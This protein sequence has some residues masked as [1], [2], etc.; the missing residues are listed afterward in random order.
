MS[1][2]QAVAHDP[3]R[4]LTR[5][6]EKMQSAAPFGP[7]DWG[8]AVWDL[9]GRLTRAGK[10]LH[11]ATRD[12]LLFIEHRSSGADA[13]VPFAASF[14]DFAKAVICARHLRSSQTVG[15][16]RVSVRALRY[17]Y[18]ALREETLCDPCSLEHRHFVLAETRARKREK[19]SSAY[20]VGQR[21]EE[22]AVLVD[23]HG[24]AKV[25]LQ[26]RSAIP[27]GDVDAIA[28]KMPETETLSALGE[29][30]G[31]DRI[32]ED[33]ALLIR[34][35][36]VDLLVAT[37]FRIG[38]VLTLPVNPIARH[39][40]EI[41]LRYW[42][43]K[44]GKL[45]VKTIS[46]VHRELVER[47]VTDLM[48]ACAKARRLAAWCERNPG[49][50]ALPRHLPTQMT[51]AHFATLGLD[52]KP[53][54]WLRVHEVPYRR[55]H[56]AIE[57]DKRDLENALVALRD[58]RPLIRTSYAKQHLS[59]SLIVVF[60][61]ELHAKRKV[62]RFVPTGVS[63]QA[64]SDFL[65]GREKHGNG[66]VF[67]QFNLRDASGNFHRI[68]THQFRHWI[69]TIAKRGG[70]SEVELARWMGRRRIAD[71]RAYDHR[72]QEERVEEARAVIR[73]GRAMG[74]IAEVYQSLRLADAEA[75]LAAQVN[76]VLTTPYGMCVHDY[77]QG[78]CERHFSCGGCGEL[79]RRKGSS[80]ERAALAAMLERTRETLA[81]AKAE[82]NDETYGASNWVARNQ[83]LEIDLITML[84]VDDDG[85]KSNGELVRVWPQSRRKQRARVR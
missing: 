21:L 11:I 81:A 23:Q 65:G 80:E 15:A 66:G 52:G 37:G 9:T 53:L 12:A 69:S 62:N 85:T 5:F 32:Y 55:Q 34:M 14:A 68:T 28:T 71:N 6:I 47:A 16:H 70:L 50:A 82:A 51:A 7:L 36:A 64:I 3:R 29:I 42:P 18:D 43:E 41:G 25:R 61:N 26:Y 10:R 22:I 1:V 56:K 2:V 84:A 58:D 49:R 39:G 20:R 78:P 4:A 24:I 83:R 46:S 8:D 38:E 72:T 19:I 44:G 63:W 17:L 27:K 74:A 54:Q 60:L 30:S 57:F 79:L 77:G 35:R 67:S 75:F 33:R 45:R 73:S 31:S 13:A 48:R 59:Q 40:D 76:A